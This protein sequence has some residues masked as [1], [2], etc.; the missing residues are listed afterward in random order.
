MKRSAAICFLAGFLCLTLTPAARAQRAGKPAPPPA[1][2]E[3]L[4]K[5]IKVPPGF[6]AT[7]FAAP[8]QVNYPTCI[9]AAPTG[10]VFIGVDQMGSLGRQS[11]AGWV[12]RCTDPTGSGKA[13]RIQTFA[14][15]D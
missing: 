12:L 1:T 5:S 4:L 2:T 9:D 14:K 13:D 3:E 10:E 6:K 15:M 8:P 7:I 11:D